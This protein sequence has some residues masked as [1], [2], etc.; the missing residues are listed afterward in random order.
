L[1]SSVLHDNDMQMAIAS[2]ILSSC[3][4]RRR[5]FGEALK[6][7]QK[8]LN[9]VSSS[10]DEDVY[11]FNTL[12]KVVDCYRFLLLQLKVNWDKEKTK[13]QF[14]HHLVNLLPTRTPES[15]FYVKQISL[16]T[17]LIHMK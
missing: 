4:K 1:L 12:F 7:A 9:I 14:T 3:Y 10:F 13:T 8:A 6:F 15:S 17:Q 2:D 11:L 5:K 16:L